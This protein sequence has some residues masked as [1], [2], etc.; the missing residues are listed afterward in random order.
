LYG[1][2]EFIKTHINSAKLIFFRWYEVFDKNVRHRINFNVK[3][4]T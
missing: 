1:L 3:I 4:P 2:S